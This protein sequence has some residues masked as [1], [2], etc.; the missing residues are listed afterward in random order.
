MHAQLIPC[1]AG[2][3]LSVFNKIKAV[4]R[5]TVLEIPPTAWSSG[6]QKNE[7]VRS[8]LGSR[9][10]LPALK[11]YAS[12]RI[13]PPETAEAD[14][15]PPAAAAAEGPETSGGNWTTVLLP[16]NE[17]T[18]PLQKL[19]NKSTSLRRHGRNVDIEDLPDIP[20]GIDDVE[21][22]GAVAVVPAGAAAAAAAATPGD[23][24]PS[25][26][27]LPPTRTDALS[28]IHTHAHAHTRSHTGEVWE[29]AGK[30]AV[31]R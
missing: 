11:Q 8:G 28:H 16:L 22:G 1:S 14:P 12:G 18:P 7:G 27:G 29:A 6:A 5:T 25:R 9:L 21:A 23:K 4:Q 20:D 24:R 31:I 30:R 17:K 2:G 19:R 15:R 10:K 13:E 26:Y 3:T